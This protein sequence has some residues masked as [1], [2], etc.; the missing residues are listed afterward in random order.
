M[1]DGPIITIAMIEQKAVNDF[2]AGRQ[3]HEHG[4]NWHAAALPVYLAK[5]DSCKEFAESVADK[6]A[7]P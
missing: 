4:F 5:F 1:T 2:A 7:R 3:R 6:G